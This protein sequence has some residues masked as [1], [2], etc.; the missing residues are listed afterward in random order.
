MCVYIKGLS[1]LLAL[2]YIPGLSKKICEKGKPKIWWEKMN[3]ALPKP[4]KPQKHI[5]LKNTDQK[6]ERIL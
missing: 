2:K 4:R 5:I 1:Y 6:S 3:I